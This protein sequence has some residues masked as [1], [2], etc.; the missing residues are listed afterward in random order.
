MECLLEWGL[1][2]AKMLSL[3]V[4][5]R[6]KADDDFLRLIVTPVKE[7]DLH[8]L[9]LSYSLKY[10]SRPSFASIVFFCFSFVAYFIL[11]QTINKC[12]LDKLE[13]K[14]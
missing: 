3:L 6:V 10:P 14:I 1:S 8:V 12:N 7:I 11:Q 13:V 9:H 2:G 4:G 5:D